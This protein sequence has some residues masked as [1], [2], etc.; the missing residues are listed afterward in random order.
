MKKN[1]NN[2]TA[3]MID[4]I[5]FKNFTL[6]FEKSLLNPAGLQ[7]AKRALIFLKNLF[8]I[9]HYNNWN[10]FIKVCPALML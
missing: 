8:F 1:N 5:F 3:A 7:Q 4:E 6:I 10:N 2:K 9:R